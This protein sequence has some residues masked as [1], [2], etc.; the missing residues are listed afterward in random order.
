MASELRVNTLKDASGNHSIAT[1]VVFDGTAKVW[2]VVTSSASVTAS[3]NIASGTDHGTGDYSYALT[4]AFSSANHA[5]TAISSGASGGRMCTSNTART[6]ASIIALE[7]ET[8]GGASSDDNQELSTH[9][10]LA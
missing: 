8:H 9:G 2:G 5:T 7:V 3:A 4:S 6:S 1:S 10:D